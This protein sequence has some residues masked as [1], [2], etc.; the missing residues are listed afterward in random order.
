MTSK[1]IRTICMTASMGL[2]AAGSAPRV[3]AEAPSILVS[4]GETP[5]Q[6]TY[7]FVDPE[8]SDG[9]WVAI[10]F[11]R[12]PECSA[13]AGFNLL[14]FVDFPNAFACP[15]TVAVTELWDGDDLATAGG[16]W[17]SPPWSPNF[18]TPLNAFWRGQG[19][20]PIYFVEVRELRDATADGVLTIQELTTLPS[21]QK[22]HATEYQF[23][24]LNSSRANS[25]RT[26]REGHTQTAARGLLED[27]RS[28]QLYRH[29]EFR[30][31]TYLKIDFN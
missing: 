24:Q 16:P 9:G 2:V 17:Q 22:G 13:I 23:V 18:R 26:A 15:L 12:D 25:Y 5:G 4:P 27:G 7:T 21:L 3:A 8:A 11:H 10:D 20:V 1:T 19:A 28:F 31:V 29:T 6:F 30:T 14:L